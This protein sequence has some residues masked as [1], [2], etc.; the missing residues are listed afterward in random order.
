MDVMYG[1]CVCEYQH[2]H[3]QPTPRNIC[4]QKMYS[5]SYVSVLIVL[6]SIDLY[7]RIRHVSIA[8]RRVSIAT[9]HVSDH[10]IYVYSMPLK[11]CVQL[12]FLV[13]AYIYVCVM[14]RLYPWAV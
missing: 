13:A 11:Y 4:T 5:N 10:F 6:R 14:S 8:T 1:I 3:I 7:A 12:M 9:R 2:T